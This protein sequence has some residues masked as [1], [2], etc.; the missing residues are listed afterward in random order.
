MKIENR[1]ERTVVKVL[2]DSLSREWV[3]LHSVHGRTRSGDGRTVDWE[4]DVVLLHRRHG[5]I[6]FEVKGGRPI[7]FDYQLGRWEQSGHVM[8]VDPVAQARTAS[9]GSTNSRRSLLKN[10]AAG[11][12]FASPNPFG[13]GYA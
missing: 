5:A 9:Y 10:A 7:R 13:S 6:A 2:A 3:V 12:T 1:G 4:A 11:C 8:T